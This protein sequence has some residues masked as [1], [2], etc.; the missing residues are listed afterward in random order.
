MVEL[1]DIAQDG[2]ARLMTKGWLKTSHRNTDESKSK[3]YQPFH[4]HTKSTPVE[5][6]KI[7]EYA[8]DIRETPNVFRAGYRIQL[9]IKG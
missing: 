3:L 5:P 2:S 1:G 9:V 6:G 8:I 4:P 7:Y